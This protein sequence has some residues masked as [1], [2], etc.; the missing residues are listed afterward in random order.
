MERIHTKNLAALIDPCKNRY[1]A[2]TTDQLPQPR[3]R[4]LLNVLKAMR[5]YLTMGKAQQGLLEENKQKQK[6][7]RIKRQLPMM[8]KKPLVSIVIPVYK[9]L[10]FLGEAIDCALSQTYSNIEVAVVDD[11]SPD[12]GATEFVARSYAPAPWQ[13][14]HL[15]RRIYPWCGGSRVQRGKGAG[16][17]EETLRVPGLQRLL[18]QRRNLYAAG[19]HGGASGKDAGGGRYR[20]G[21]A[22]LLLFHDGANENAD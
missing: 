20:A 3:R 13:F 17:A 21:V 14:Q 2:Y 19:R 12:N 15:E 9:G 11:G 4:N 22:Y 6:Q 8:T 10:N 7:G 18:S 5:N 1:L 16:R